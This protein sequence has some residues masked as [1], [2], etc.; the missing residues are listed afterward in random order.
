MLLIQSQACWDQNMNGREIVHQDFNGGIAGAI[1][2]FWTSGPAGI[3]GGA[4]AG[5]VG[6]SAA[7]TLWQVAGAYVCNVRT[8]G[9]APQSNKT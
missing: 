7:E 2:G 9:F 1:G 3:L 4:F 6:L 8:G 5:A